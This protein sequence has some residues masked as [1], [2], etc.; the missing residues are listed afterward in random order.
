[1]SDDRNMTGCEPIQ[2]DEYD[3]WNDIPAMM[4]HAAEVRY[5]LWRGPFWSPPPRG[6]RYVIHP[7]PVAREAPAIIRRQRPRMGLRFTVG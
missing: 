7:L 3:A 6:R 1:M 5:S 2:G 4:R